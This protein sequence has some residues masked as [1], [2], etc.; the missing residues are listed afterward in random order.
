MLQLLTGSQE[1][2]TKSIFT[3]LNIDE[4]LKLHFNQN[5]IKKKEYQH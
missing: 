3:L 2:L 1:D 4:V 5:N